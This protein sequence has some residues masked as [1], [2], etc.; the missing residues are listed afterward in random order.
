MSTNVLELPVFVDVTDVMNSMKCSRSAAYEH[1]RKAG[2]RLPGQRGQLRVP[3]YVW[4]RYVRARFD[5]ESR[6][7]E[8]L[9][10]GRP[11]KTSS[12]SRIEV[13]RPRTQPRNAT[14]ETEDPS[15]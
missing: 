14:P 12:F 6:A 1:L 4:L 11:R 2:G 3:I 5:P 9:R 10:R 13:T 15:Q 7:C 8:R